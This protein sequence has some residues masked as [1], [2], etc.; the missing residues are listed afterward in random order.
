[1]PRPLAVPLRADA[2]VDMLGGLMFACMAHP[3]Q[4]NGPPGVRK[5]H[6]S[7]YPVRQALVRYVTFMQN[8]YPTACW[9]AC[10]VKGFRVRLV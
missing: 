4:A 3:V 1:M 10:H 5:H 7:L 6:A 9:P 2:S 8:E